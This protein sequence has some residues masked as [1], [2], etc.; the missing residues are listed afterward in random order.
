MPQKRKRDSPTVESVLADC[1]Q[2]GTEDLHLVRDALDIL[3]EQLERWEDTGLE[4]GRRPNGIGYIEKKRLTTVGL[5][6]T[7]VFAAMEFIIPYT[8]GMSENLRFRVRQS[9]GI[10]R[11]E[12]L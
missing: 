1:Y 4:S 8:W 5:I 2:F 11:F 3:I 12:T 7:F 9:T 6:A 10:I